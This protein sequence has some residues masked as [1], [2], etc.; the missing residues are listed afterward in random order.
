MQ[1]NLNCDVVTIELWIYGYNCIKITLNMRKPNQ[2]NY[3]KQSYG[4]IF[5]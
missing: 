4:L 5:F 2:Q 1:Q 3:A